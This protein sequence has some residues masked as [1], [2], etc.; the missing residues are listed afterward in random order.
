MTKRSANE[1]IKG[2]SYQ[3]D[4]TVIE[5]LECNHQDTEFVVEGIEDVDVLQENLST[6]IQYKYYEGTDY[7]HSVIKPAVIA[8][9]RHFNTLTA[10]KAALVKYK[11]YGHFKSGQEKLEPDFS[12]DVLKK[13]FLSYKKEGATH[14]VYDELGLTDAQLELFQQSLGIDLHRNS[15]RNT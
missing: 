10:S 8:M 4:R 12:L 13:S 11:L 15:N 5:I 2:Y 6:F 7:N 14:I 3:F 9:L 1:S